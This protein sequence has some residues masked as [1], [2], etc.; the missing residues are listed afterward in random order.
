MFRINNE[1]YINFLLPMLKF[2]VIHPLEVFKTSL[3]YKI[4]QTYCSCGDQLVHP[5]LPDNRLSYHIA[6]RNQC[7]YDGHADGTNIFWSYLIDKHS[8]TK[9]LLQHAFCWPVM[10]IY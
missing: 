6:G 5:R 8:R 1:R 7:I 10:F 2:T 4:F 3:N 9:L